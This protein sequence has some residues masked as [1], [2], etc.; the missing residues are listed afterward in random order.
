MRWRGASAQPLAL[1]IIDLDHFKRDQRRAR[2]C[3]R[4]P[5]AGR[6]RR[7]AGRHIAGASDVACRYG[8]EEFCLLMPRTDAATARRKAAVRCCGAGV[9]CA[10]SSTARCSRSRASPPAW[11]T[12]GWLPGSPDALLKA[13][14]DAC[15]RPSATAATGSG[16]GHRRDRAMHDEFWLRHGETALNAARVMQPADTPL[17][18]RGLAP[19]RGGGARRLAAMR[20]RRRCSAATCRAPGR[21][22]RRWRGHCGLPV[23]S[24][25]RCCASATSAHC[26]AGPT[27]TLGV[28]P[29]D[30]GRRAA[31]AASR[32]PHFLARAA[33]GLGRGA[34]GRAAWTARWWWSRTAC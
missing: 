20:P 34:A 30:A 8:G 15:S 4:R 17:S 28:D 16:G 3:R 13:A 12:P 14:D 29:A 18:A 1:V 32:W 11:P 27:T 21:P 19:G 23:P 7:A 24:P 5:A 22:R 33:R 9:R 26:A 31:G 25:S 6:L 2:P 10:S